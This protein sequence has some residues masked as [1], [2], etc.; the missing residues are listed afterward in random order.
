[1]KILINSHNKSQKALDALFQSMKKCENFKNFEIIVCIGGHY[2][3]ENYITEKQENITYIKCPHNSI[4]FTA[5]ITVMELYGNM[6]NTNYLYIHDTC[7]VGPNFFINVENIERTYTNITTLKLAPYY[8]MNIGV[9]SSEVLAHNKQF[10][11]NQKNTDEAKVQHF[12]IKG[13]DNED[14]IFIRDINS[15]VI[16]EKGLTK[17]TGPLDCYGTGVMRI[18]LYYESLDLYKI[19]ANWERK[20]TYELNN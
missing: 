1:M 10:L 5:L 15:R 18:V 20:P 7:T 6:P 12:K 14:S 9:Y 13:V 4:D 8:A 2:E 16:Y 17:A 19:K 11:L 3:L